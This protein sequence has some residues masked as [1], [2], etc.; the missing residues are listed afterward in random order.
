[1]VRRQLRAARRLRLRRLLVLI[2]NVLPSLNDVSAPA[3]SPSGG[4]RALVALLNAANRCSSPAELEASL[5]AVRAE[6]QAFVAQVDANHGLLLAVEGA[7]HARAV[8]DEAI[9]AQTAAIDQVEAL[10]IERVPLDSDRWPLA[11]A[12]LEGAGGRVAAAMA[13]MLRLHDEVP[14]IS[15]TPLVNEVYALALNVLKGHNG[16]II[17]L[18]HRL[19]PLHELVEFLSRARTEFQTRNPNETEIVERL[20]SATEDLRQAV[21]G[22]YVF[23]EGASLVDLSNALTLFDRA[24]GPIGACLKAMKMIESDRADFSEAVP[25][26]RL[27]EAVSLLVLGVPVDL[28]PLVEA[29][30]AFH[31]AMAHDLEGLAATAWLGHER[32]TE[33]MTGMAAQLDELAALRAAVRQFDGD[34]EALAAHVEGLRE[35]GEVF[36]NLQAELEEEQAG[37]PDFKNAPYL[38]ALFEAMTGV[39]FGVVPDRALAESL[40]VV[41]RLHRAFEAR[42]RLDVLEGHEAHE[43][44]EIDG[45]IAEQ[46]RAIALLTQ[47]LESGARDLLPMAYDAFVPSGLRLQQIREAADRAAVAEVTCVVCGAANPAG[48]SRCASCSKQLPVLSNFSAPSAFQM[49]DVGVGRAP[50]AEIGENFRLVVRV[51]EQVESGRIDR[52]E[53]MQLVTPFMSTVADT[54]ARMTVVRGQVASSGDAAAL[55]RQK[56]LDALLERVE[57]VAEGLRARLVARSAGLA[58]I[59]DELIELGGQLSAFEHQRS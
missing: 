35:A 5:D 26:Q 31:A 15:D 1:M 24:V 21:G 48:S 53:A 8:F 11:L 7:T 44:N 27:H 34:L 32:R 45:L 39:W 20:D 14:R 19:G 6:T 38:Q 37:Q 40:E 22:F 55:E 33:L 25:L 51:I 54:R 13:A 10:V 50:E 16:A 17:G 59:R 12:T 47:Y 41:Q 28:A 9:A 18:A 30:E 58:D 43:T 56:V 36:D 49:L 4:G 57:L 52:D 3:A 42:L 23:I 46:G 2:N 29:L